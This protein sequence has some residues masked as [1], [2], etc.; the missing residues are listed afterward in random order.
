VIVDV[1]GDQVDDDLMTAALRTHH[2]QTV[3]HM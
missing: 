3:T 2:E 1:P